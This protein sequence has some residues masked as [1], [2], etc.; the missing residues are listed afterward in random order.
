[1]IGVPSTTDRG[2]GQGK[3][4]S[5]FNGAKLEINLNTFHTV[6]SGQFF[7]FPAASLYPFYPEDFLQNISCRKHMPGLPR[8]AQVSCRRQKNCQACD[9]Y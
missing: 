8:K 1:M 2:A 3:G 4:F 7:R 5:P 9:D 6:F